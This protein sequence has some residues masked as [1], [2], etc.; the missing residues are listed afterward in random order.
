MQKWVRDLEAMLAA[1]RSAGVT[2]RV[3]LRRPSHAG[4]EGRK[5]GDRTK[6]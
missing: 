3:N 1:K 5:N 4:D 6:R 2:L